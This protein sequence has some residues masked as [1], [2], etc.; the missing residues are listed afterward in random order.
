MDY[1]SP[2]F[3]FTFLSKHAN[4]LHNIASQAVLHN[5]TKSPILRKNIVTGRLFL[6]MYVPKKVTSMLDIGNC[7]VKTK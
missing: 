2:R 6:E 1:Q 4:V 3:F 7:S 5:E